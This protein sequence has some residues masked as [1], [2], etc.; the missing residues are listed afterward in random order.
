MD[1]STLGRLRA[2]F[3]CVI[4]LTGVPLAWQAGLRGGGFV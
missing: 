2:P 1:D 3:F 4:Y